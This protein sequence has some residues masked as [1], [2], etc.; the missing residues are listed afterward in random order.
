M[1]IIELKNSFHNTSVRV[2]V[3]ADNP[4]EAW[5]EIQAAAYGNRAANARL[6]RVRKALCGF[7]GCHCGT[8]I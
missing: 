7:T 3:Y 8:V 5:F 2:R 6:R 1:H 4:A